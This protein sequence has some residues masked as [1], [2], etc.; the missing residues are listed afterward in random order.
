MQSDIE[1]L[2]EQLVDGARAGDIEDVKAALDQG[3]D[4][5]ATDEYG[6]TGQ[7]SL[8]IL[9]HKGLRYDQYF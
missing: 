4:V 9:S 8:L 2:V 7:S 3:V 1:E 6:R 5:N